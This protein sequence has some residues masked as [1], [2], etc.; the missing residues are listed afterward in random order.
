VEIEKASAWVFA[1]DELL[2]DHGVIPDIRPPVRI[3]WRRRLRWR[4]CGKREALARR[5]FKV[6]AGYDAPDGD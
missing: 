5:A 3:P 2:M 6:I 4:L 1:P